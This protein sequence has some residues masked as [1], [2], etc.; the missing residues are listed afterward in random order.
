VVGAVSLS[1]EITLEINGVS[2][3]VT[4][5]VH[6]YRYPFP[7]VVFHVR[8]LI[9]VELLLGGVAVKPVERA[10]GVTIRV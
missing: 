5:R 2:V 4:V 6:G 7:Q 10:L 1:L 8:R 3:I 9:E